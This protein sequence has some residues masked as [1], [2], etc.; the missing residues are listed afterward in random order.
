MLFRTPKIATP[1]GTGQIPVAGVVE[2]DEA[3]GEV[4]LGAVLPVVVAK[5]VTELTSSV[6]LS[7]RT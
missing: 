6:V 1:P 4:F 5:M 2:A 3:D 7:L